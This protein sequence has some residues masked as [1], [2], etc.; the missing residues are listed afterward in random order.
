MNRREFIAKSCT[1]C[2]GATAVSALV[3]SC[4][5]TRYT[6]GNLGNDGL[7]VSMDEFKITKQGKTAYRPFIIVRNESLQ[8]PIYV[9]RFGETEYSALWMRCSHQGA[10]LQASGDQL[11]CSAHGSEF[12][13]TGKVTNGPADKDLRSFP[14]SVNNN[15]LFID[16]RKP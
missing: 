8:Y 10:E 13:N 11:Q 12:S 7:T 9:Y 14:V 2:L 1:A 4:A 16:L 15:E 3:S 5:S 6:S